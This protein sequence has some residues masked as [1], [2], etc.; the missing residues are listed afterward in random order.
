MLLVAG[1]WEVSLIR[2]VGT[3][4][5]TWQLHQQGGCVPRIQEQQEV[6]FSCNALLCGAS[7]VI[8]ATS[9]ACSE[10]PCQKP[11]SGVRDNCCGLL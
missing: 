5:S 10:T 2:H 1:S 9:G 4:W 11:T 3:A 8:R 6:V 7:E